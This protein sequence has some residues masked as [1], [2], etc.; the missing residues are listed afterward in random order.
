MSAALSAV[1]T[2]VEFTKI[3]AR[4]LPFTATVDCATKFDPIT[5]S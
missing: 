2:K 3:V 4:R 1:S 5:F